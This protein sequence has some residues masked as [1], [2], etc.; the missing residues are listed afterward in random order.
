MKFCDNC[1]SLLSLSTKTGSLVFI[2]QVCKSDF[3]SKAED[4]LL[5]SKD[6]KEKTL[7]VYKKLIKNAPYIASIPRA[8]NPC[9]LCKEKIVSYIRIGTEYQQLFICKCGNYW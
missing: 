2:C 5:Y 7:D 1:G 3:E 4:T 9:P 6:K 8:E